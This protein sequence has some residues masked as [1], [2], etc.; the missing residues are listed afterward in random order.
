MLEERRAGLKILFGVGVEV[1]RAGAKE[2]R[3]VE[4]WVNA[5]REV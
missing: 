5:N 2:A 4:L 3:D 1:E